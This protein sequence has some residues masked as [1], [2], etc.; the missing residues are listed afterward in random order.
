MFLV[1]SDATGFGSGGTS[2][3][4]QVGPSLT[5]KSCNTTDPGVDFFFSLDSAL[6]QCRLVYHS[7]TLR[8]PRLTSTRRSYAF[9]DYDKAIQPVIIT[10]SPTHQPL[11]VELSRTYSQQGFIPGG[12]TFQLK[13]PTGPTSFDWKANLD[14]GTSVVFSM[15]DSQGR[16]GR[17]RPP[18]LSHPRLNNFL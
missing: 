9:S 7:D 12:N 17:C 13:P 14:A 10:V 11:N 5:G 4:T 15:T 18:R 3:I 2:L 6:T 1:M 8:Q 16:N